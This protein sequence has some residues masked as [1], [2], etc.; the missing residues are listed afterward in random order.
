M[1][2]FLT[3]IAYDRWVLPALLL[4]PLVGAAGIWLHG[5][6]SSAPGGKGSDEVATGYATWPAVA[7]LVTLAVEFIVS[8]GL[9]WSYV[10]GG[11][12]WQHAVDVGWIPTWGIRFTLG[13][14][15]I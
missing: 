8:V 15:G 12:R 6:L 4:I 2:A 9:W 5:A 14:D 3:S 1:N 11:P 10:P 7:G 13:V